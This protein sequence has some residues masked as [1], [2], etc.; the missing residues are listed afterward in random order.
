[1][2]GWSIGA[3]LVLWVAISIA[4]TVVLLHGLEDHGL[5]STPHRQVAVGWLV[6]ED[7]TTVGILVLLPAIAGGSLWPVTVWA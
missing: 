4:S 1:M 5:L 7:L 2:W 3:G 6:L